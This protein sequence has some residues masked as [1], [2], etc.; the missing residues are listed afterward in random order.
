MTKKSGKQKISAAPY[1][2]VKI[3]GTPRGLTC[4]PPF[5]RVLPYLTEVA[6]ITKSN[7]YG[8]S[9]NSRGIG[10]HMVRTLHAPLVDRTRGAP[11]PLINFYELPYPVV[12]KRNEILGVKK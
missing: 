12:E 11:P 2:A 4:A 5:V 10:M 8:H 3:R 6:G 1:L 9:S 7:V